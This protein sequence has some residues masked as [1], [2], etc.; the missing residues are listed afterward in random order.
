MEGMMTLV[1]SHCLLFYFPPL[2]LA[3][4]KNS[5]NVLATGGY[6]TVNEPKIHLRGMAILKENKW[7]YV[8]GESWRG[9]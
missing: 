4:I 5:K 2:R 6:Y 9:M 7:E 1:A 8:G 3:Y